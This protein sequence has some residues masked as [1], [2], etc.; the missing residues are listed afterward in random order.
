MGASAP[1]PKCTAL[2]RLYDVDDR[3]LYVG[4]TNDVTKRWL[5]HQ[6]TKQWWA[7][8]VRKTVEWFDARVDAEC[9]EIEAIKGERPR[10]NRAHNL[11]GEVA[12]EFL[13]E[14]RQKKALFPRGHSDHTALA[15]FM[16]RKIDEGEWLP[17]Q[18]LPRHS[19]MQEQFMVSQGTLQRALATLLHRGCITNRN[20][21]GQYV[22]N[23]PQDC[24]VRVPIGR[25]E[26]AATILRDHMTPE[27]LNSLRVFLGD[28]LEIPHKQS[29]DH[30]RSD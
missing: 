26:M 20:G 27:D 15:G 10:Y 22:V 12:Q 13:E 4:I 29:N 9:A 14:L 25:P 17:G 6:C 2:Y 5:D 8:V 18:T 7:L 23:L 24:T 28:Q 3:L 16:R 30:L 21:S 1:K 19:S 11:R